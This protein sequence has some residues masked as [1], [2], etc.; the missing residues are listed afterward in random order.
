MKKY[1]YLFLFSALIF[2]CS[3]SETDNSIDN[4]TIE[5]HIQLIKNHEGK[6]EISFDE[7]PEVSQNHINDLENNI[8]AELI[9][10]AENIGYEVKLR[11]QSRNL[12]SLLNI[13]YIY[14]NENGELLF[15]E[16]YDEDNDGY[17]D[18][19]EEWGNYMCFDIQF[20]IQITMPD[21]S[22]VSVV[23]EDELFEAV[24]LY[25]EMSDEYDELPEINF[26][27]NIVFY[28]ENENGNEQQE[29]IEI[30]SYEELE[31]Y[32]DVCP[33]E[34]NNGWD[35]EDWYEIDC[36]DLV[37]PLTIVNPEGEVLTVDSENNLHEYIDQYYENCNSNDCGDFNLYYPLTVEYYS[38]TNDQV[39][40]LTINSEEEL[41]ELLDEHCYNNDDDGDGEDG[42]D[43]CGE[44]VYPVTVEAPNGDQFTG[45]SEEEIMTFIEEWSSNNCNTMECDTDFE[46][47]FPITM[48]FEDDQG[49]II[50][51]T[52]QSEVML[53]EITEQYC[54]D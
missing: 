26:P 49:D 45:N 10:Y 47:V 53:E 39:Q 50:V 14:F 33:D 25:Y 43:T 29:V 18:V 21:D 12:V 51:M 31:M 48:E 54:E 41:E 46:L 3:D 8:T 2:S 30:G 34:N 27:I 24:D 4:L 6:I 32:F 22:Q 36:F 28:F 44:I 42:L 15:D 7:L 16:N 5:E 13:L 20:P 38:E 11:R 37:Y 9:L 40:T 19:F 17:Y 52:I 1:I 23:N 35:D